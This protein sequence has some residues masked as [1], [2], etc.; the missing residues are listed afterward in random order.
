MQRAVCANYKVLSRHSLGG[1]EE[2]FEKSVTIVGV[3]AEIRTG[4]LS[5]TNQK[6]RRF[7]QCVR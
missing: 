7:S 6:H 3:R 4:H 5:D 2:N 1:T